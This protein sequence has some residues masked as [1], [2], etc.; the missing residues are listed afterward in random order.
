MLLK[1]SEKPRKEQEQEENRA[2]IPPAGPSRTGEREGR[3]GKL[4]SANAQRASQL[5]L[6]NGND[7]VTKNTLSSFAPL[8]ASGVSPQNRALGL[9]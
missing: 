8:P 7:F 6:V 4:H 3:K 5:Q 9:I 2:I 1:C